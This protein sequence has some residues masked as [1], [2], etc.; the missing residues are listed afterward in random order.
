MEVWP[1]EIGSK[2]LNAR[3]LMEGLYGRPKAILAKLV[4]PIK[5]P[6]QAGRKD[7]SFAAALGVL[8]QA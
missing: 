8:L 7:S 2:T 5:S 4:A 1:V 3:I 6:C